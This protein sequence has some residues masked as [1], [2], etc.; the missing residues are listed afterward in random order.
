MLIEANGKK[1]IGQAI[2]F[3]ERNLTN[4]KPFI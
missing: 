3:S 4:L 2:P 1:L